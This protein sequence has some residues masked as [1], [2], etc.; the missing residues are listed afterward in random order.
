MGKRTAGKTNTLQGMLWIFLNFFN[1]P[2]D[3]VI[4]MTN[5]SINPVFKLNCKRDRFNRR[6]TIV[7]SFIANV[8]LVLL[9]ALRNAV[10]LIS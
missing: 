9:I 8:M 6:T 10:L 5:S 1:N 4:D 3:F 2:V 7:L